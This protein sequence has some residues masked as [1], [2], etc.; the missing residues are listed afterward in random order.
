MKNNNK[1]DK[2]HWQN[3][4]MNVERISIDKNQYR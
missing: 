4:Y 2:L 3:I 1:D